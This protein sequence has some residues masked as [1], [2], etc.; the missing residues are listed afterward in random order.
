MSKQ[1]RL[2][3][4]ALKNEGWNIFYSPFENFDAGKI[5]DDGVGNVAE[6]I[7]SSCVELSSFR[8]PPLT[9]AHLIRFRILRALHFNSKIPMMK[10][11]AVPK[12][13]SLI[14]SRRGLNFFLPF[15]LLQNTDRVPLV[16][17]LDF[18]RITFYDF[19]SPNF[20]FSSVKSLLFKQVALK[21]V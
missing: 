9:L 4:F 16:V 19:F 2:S 6:I 21:K 3:C 12:N 20:S 18:W 10:F 7:S 5:S 17:R 13:L 8:P 14:L 15:L 11:Q 1:R